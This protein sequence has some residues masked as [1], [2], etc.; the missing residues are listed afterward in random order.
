VF[1]Q[2]ALPSLQRLPL[3]QLWLDHLLALQLRAGPDDGWDEGTFVLLSLTGNIDCTLAAHRYR[4]CLTDTSTFD[5]RTL[6]EIVLAIRL[7]TGGD[8]IDAVHDR[9]LDPTP[10]K[11][12]GLNS[13]RPT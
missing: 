2:D 11:R 4:R 6:D 10:L 1:R 7:T 12:A 9:Y 8:W 5:A 3:Q 13:L